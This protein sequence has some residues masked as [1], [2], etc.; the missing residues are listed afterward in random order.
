MTYTFVKQWAL[1]FGMKFFAQLFLLN[2]WKSQT[3]DSFVNFN[4]TCTI[5][6]FLRAYEYP[7]A[8]INVSFLFLQSLQLFR[9]DEVTKLPSGMVENFWF[10]ENFLVSYC[11]NIVSFPLYA[12][13]MPSLSDLDISEYQKLISA[14]TG[15]LHFHTGLR[16]LCICPSS[17]MV[18][19]ETFQLI[20]DDILQLL[21]FHR[22]YVYGCL[23]W[24]T[25]P[26]QLIQLSFLIHIRTYDF[27]IKAIPHTLVNLSSLETLELRCW[28]RLKTCGFVTSYLN[29]GICG[30]MI[31]HCKKLWW[32]EWTTLFPWKC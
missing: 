4:K 25:L 12:C 19:F 24:N 22:L 1:V 7:S 15:R 32:M 27:W 26:Y 30:Y 20:F 18:N 31:I 23:H 5:F 16:E 2:S 28:K 13:K 17:E 3:V 21:S 8:P 6:I 9:C 29:F 10:L 14:P 11:N